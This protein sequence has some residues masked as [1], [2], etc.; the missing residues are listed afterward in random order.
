MTSLVN[1]NNKIRIERAEVEQ[2]PG[3]KTVM[4]P[5]AKQGEE[6]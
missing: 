2:K 5:L 1:A 3:G 6:G 4:V